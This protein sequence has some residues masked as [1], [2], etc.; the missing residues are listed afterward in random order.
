MGLNAFLAYSLVKAGQITWETALGVVFLSGL[1]GFVLTLLGLRKRLVEAIPVSLVA[2][3]A[4]GIGLFITFIGLVNMGVIVKNEATLVSAGPMTATVTIGLAGLLTMAFLEI[5]RIKGA[6]L[7]GIAFSTLLAVIFGYVEKPASMV[8]FNFDIRPVAFRLDILGAFQWGLFGSVFT[9]MFMD[10]F[11]GVGTLVACCHEAGMVDERGK[12]K[13]LGRLLAID[14]AAS[15]VGAVLGTSNVT[16]Y[17][18]SGAGIQQGGRTGLTALVTALCFV[19]ALLFVPLVGIVPPYA[20][21]PALVMVGLF[22]MKEIR[23]IDFGNLEEA[24]PS[25]IILVMIALSYSISKGLAFGFISF[26]LIK[27]AAG[28]VRDIKP[29][30]WVIAVSSLLFVTMDRLRAVLNF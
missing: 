2:A 19:L 21:A 26:V 14:T 9:L 8:S 17:I 1:L 3:I 27:L 18:E 29:T 25:F 16:A 12:I 24:M 4:V 6:L 23:R 22:M 11:D 13:S 7:I 28:K 5:R 20:T 15:M 30:M 10:M